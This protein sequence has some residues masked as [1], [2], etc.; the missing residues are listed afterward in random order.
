MK[1]EVYS[2][3]VCPW[4]RIGKKNMSDA[5]AQWE[6][7]TG[8]QV[9]VTYR[10]YQLDPTLPPEGKPFH[11]SMAAKMGGAER[12]GPMLQRVT[13]AG[14]EI[15]LTFRFDRV[16]TSPNTLL[17]H[18]ITALL[19]ADLQDKW[20]NAVMDAHFEHGRNIGEIDTLLEVANSLGFDTAELRQKLEAGG[21]IAEVEHDI[22]AAKA[23]GIT[24]VPF[25][26]IDDKNALSGAYPVSQFMAAF[27]QITQQSSDA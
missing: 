11:E 5:L 18:R 24:G 16:A 3:M 25:F 13:D 7:Q 27:R 2:D 23:L 9:P 19:P 12:F 14:A 20:V 21:G 17:A 22:E 6:E 15:G 26:I 8:G 1:I 10:A 4:C